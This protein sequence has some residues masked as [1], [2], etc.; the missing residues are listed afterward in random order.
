MSDD[1]YSDIHPDV[2][3]ALDMARDLRN[4]IADLRE[5]IDN[6]RGCVRSP[7]GYAAAEVDAMGRLI[8]LT[9]FNDACAKLNGRRLAEEIMDSIRTSMAEASRNYD[10]IMNG[11]SLAE[12]FE[13]IAE[14]EPSQGQKQT[15]Q[16]RPE[17][18]LA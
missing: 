16:P 15:E 6:V 11:D 12:P 1:I 4:R 2:K 18:G 9:L 7:G 5:R 13:E 14:A 8:K 3:A 17:T 10:E